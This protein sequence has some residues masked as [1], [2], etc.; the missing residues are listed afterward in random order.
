LYLFDPIFAD[1]HH[2][3]HKLRGIQPRESSLA[4]LS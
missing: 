3:H 2:A 1:N 4:E